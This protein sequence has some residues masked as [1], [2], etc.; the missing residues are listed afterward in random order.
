MSIKNHPNEKSSSL[1]NT[2][3]NK[4]NDKVKHNIST[5]HHVAPKQV[6]KPESPSKDE[7]IDFIDE[8]GNSQPLKK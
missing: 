6:I 7:Q 1:L 2:E 3:D 5:N 8:G 4:I